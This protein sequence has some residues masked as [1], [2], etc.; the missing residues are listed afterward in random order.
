MMQLKKPKEPR[1]M[2]LDFVT[3]ENHSST[4]M[5]DNKYIRVNTTKQ[6]MQISVPYLKQ[7]SITLV[8]LLMS[9][10]T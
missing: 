2:A 5:T 7:L 3:D 10:F 4:A 8:L 9:C 1:K 6:N